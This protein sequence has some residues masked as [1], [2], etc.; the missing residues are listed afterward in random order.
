MAQK[1]LDVLSK[2]IYGMFQDSYVIPKLHLE[3]YSVMWKALIDH[4]GI[5]IDEDD[6]KAF[7][8][9][10]NCEHCNRYMEFSQIFNKYFKN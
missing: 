4:W 10:I 6:Y 2:V 1:N 8:L 9:D 5:D 7:V 3:E